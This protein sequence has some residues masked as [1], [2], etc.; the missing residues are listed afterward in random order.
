MNGA[1]DVGGVVLMRWKDVDDL[2]AGREH[3]GKLAMLDFA[4]CYARIAARAE[5]AVST[6]VSPLPGAI[7]DVSTS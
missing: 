2:R 4:H 6:M 7:R 3:R 5:R 1:A